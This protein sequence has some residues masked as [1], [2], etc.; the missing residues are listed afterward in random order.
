MNACGVRNDLGSKP[1]VGQEG[2]EET[3]V[4][5]V[6]GE[7]QVS[8][9]ADEEDVSSS[10]D[11]DDD[12]RH[13]VNGIIFRLSSNISTLDL[14]KIPTISSFTFSNSPNNRSLSEFTDQGR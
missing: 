9:S 7:E 13:R 1:G 3:D 4:A 5:G 6:N 2:V 10:R 8:V 12:D 14:V 11:E